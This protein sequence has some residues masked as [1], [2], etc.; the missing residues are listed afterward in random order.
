MTT[1]I[2]G[3]G[4]RRRE[5][6]RLITG[7]ATFTDD[8]KLPGMVHAAILRSPH[9]HAKIKS[10]DTTAASGAPG[11]VAVYTGADTDGVLNPIP[12]AWL[13]P[14][15]D[16]KAVDHPAIAKDVVR[17][18]GDAVAVVVAEDRY[19][20]EDALELINVEYE[21]LPSVVSPEAAMQAGAPQI[22]EDAPNNQAFHW[23]AAGGDT[24]AAFA[25]ADVIVKDT[26][27]QQRLIPNAM[28]PR[29]AVANWT[30]SMGEL[31]LWST[32]QN[33]HIVR[34]LG[35]LVTGIPEHKIRVIATEVGGGFG[36]KIPMYPDE[37]IISFCSMRLDRPVKW[38]ATRSEGFLATIHGRDHIQHVELAATREGKITGIRSVVYA[39]MGAYLSTAGPGVPTILHGLIYSGP[40]DIG[41][42][43]A[44]IYGVFSNTTPVDA[45]RGA[46]RPEATFLIERLIDLLAVELGTDPVELRRKNLIPKFEDGHDVP[47]GITY[48]SGDYEPL[49][50]MVLDR[51]DYKALRQEQAR[52]RERGAYMGIGVTCYAEICG[53]G[54]SQVAG[55]V[56]FGGGLWESAIVRFHPTGKVNAYIG[57]APHGQGEETTFAQIISDE[58]G[59]DV[60]DVG[61]IHGDTS[62]TPMGW[63]TYGSR[64]TTVGGAALALAAR[65]IK[66]KARLLAA[67]LLEAAEADVEYADG[68]FFVKGSPDRSKTIQE[69]ATMANVAW[70][71]PEGME[72]GL[73]ASAFYDPPNFVYPFGTHVAVVEVDKD[74]GNVVIKRYVAGDDCGPQINPMIVEGQVHG[75]VVQGWGQ[76]LWEGA[77][78]D[79]NGQLLTGSMTDYA[80]PR[81]HMFPDM[82]VLS[83]VTP[84]PHNPLGVKGIGETGAIA[85]T[86]TIYNAVIDALR[87]L[88]VTHLDMPLTP[89]KIW[90]AI[91]QGQ[92]S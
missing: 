11:V 69:I 23:V 20:A 31:T 80:L 73:E 82:E 50:N 7:D 59:V 91:R 42:T 75:G 4:I 90:Q 29:S 17:Y 86:V 55:A 88:G 87:P 53:L 41:A 61:I 62:N 22:H 19:Q 32:S 2:F 12:C 30:R 71:M 74:N 10:I 63:G 66:E 43:K 24:D 67:H 79:D 47:S 36:S 57:T 5:D 13:P 26:I 70:N 34:F 72:P 49:L 78:Y 18:Q 38:T 58:L 33:P 14:D 84:S 9:A 92:G 45:Y 21:V 76:A 52:M 65:K 68:K 81:A 39:G 1:R 77:V 54:P 56:G 85:S 16:I 83:T 51:V 37:M 8:V 35:S 15:C 60:D 89:E 3:S 64:T 25:D 27:L 40:Y 44:D 6:P 28:E 48:D 46:G